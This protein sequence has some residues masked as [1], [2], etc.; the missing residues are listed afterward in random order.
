MLTLYERGQ[1]LINKINK[2]FFFFKK[3]FHSVEFWV[4]FKSRQAG[5]WVIFS[6]SSYHSFSRMDVRCC[7]WLWT[8]PLLPWFHTDQFK[9]S[10]HMQHWMSLIPQNGFLSRQMINNEFFVSHV[11]KIW[12]WMKYVPPALIV[13]SWLN[14]LENNSF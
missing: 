13:V 6:F 11:T 4:L 8:W 12:K 10:K 3:T 7:S 14:V 9:Y 5:Q 1:K 2:I